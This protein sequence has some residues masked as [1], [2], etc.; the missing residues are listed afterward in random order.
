MFVF[1]DALEPNSLLCAGAFRIGSFLMCDY[2]LHRLVIEKVR[3]MRAH[4]TF[5]QQ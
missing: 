5:V 3:R 4:I 1:P 2:S